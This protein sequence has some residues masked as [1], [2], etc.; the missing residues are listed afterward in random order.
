MKLKIVNLTISPETLPDVIVGDKYNVDFVISGGQEPYAIVSKSELPDG[1][2]FKK[3]FTGIEGDVQKENFDL[4]NVELI[5][6]DA[7][8]KTQTF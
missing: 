1:L 8:G 3:E 6:T 5:V 4:F 7:N 2:S